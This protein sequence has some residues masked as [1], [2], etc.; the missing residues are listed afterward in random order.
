MKKAQAIL[1]ISI[2]YDKATQKFLPFNS[3]HE[4]YAVIL[5]EVDE[6]WEEIKSKEST[7][8]S[9]ADEAIQIAAMALRF[10]IDLTLEE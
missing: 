5:E 9:M 4:G 1:L 2:E 7:S 10:L 6:L 8:Q 3:P